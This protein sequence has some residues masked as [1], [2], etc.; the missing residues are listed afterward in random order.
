MTGRAYK[1][2]NRATYKIEFGIGDKSF[3]RWNVASAILSMSKTLFL[4]KIMKTC[5]TIGLQ[6]SGTK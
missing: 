3:I 5:A 6:R 2:K 1:K 4:G